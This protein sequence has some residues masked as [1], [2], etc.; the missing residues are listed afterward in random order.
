MT[1]A[2][3]VVIAALVV[4]KALLLLDAV[5]DGRGDP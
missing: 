1:D 5:A 3:V 4:S 2:F